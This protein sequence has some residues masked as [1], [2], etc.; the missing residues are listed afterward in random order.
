MYP[1]KMVLIGV[2]ASHGRHVRQPEN[3]SKPKIKDN[4]QEISVLA[5]I[6]K[7]LIVEDLLKKIT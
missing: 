5:A 2:A 7:I 6:N 1:P 4:T 3:N